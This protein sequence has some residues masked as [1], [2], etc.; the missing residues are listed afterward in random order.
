MKQHVNRVFRYLMFI[1]L[2]LLFLKYDYFIDHLYFNA[3]MTF[4]IH[5]MVVFIL[6]AIVNRLV[7]WLASVR[8]KFQIQLITSILLILFF[9]HEMF[10]P[11][12]Y[13]EHYLKEKGL[14][15]IEMYHQLSND[16]L[17]ED[18]RVELA[19]DAMIK[20]QAYAYS[21]GQYHVAPIEDIEIIDVKRNYYQ[22]ELKV[23]GIHNGHEKRYT[24]M[25]EKEGFAFKISGFA[26]QF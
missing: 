24:Y 10:T 5:F 23:K 18:E 7:K 6:I 2:Y 8:Y 4:M 26:D 25:F 13:T 19:E 3:N 15:K 1:F 14:E 22:Y 16:E 21:V 12:F 11:Y 20:M 9:I 17:S